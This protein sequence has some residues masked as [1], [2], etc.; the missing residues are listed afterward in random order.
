MRSAPFRVC[1]VQVGRAVHV[2]GSRCGLRRAAH[3][4]WRRWARTLSGSKLS[5]TIINLFNRDPERGEAASG[6][7]VMDPRLRRY[8]VSFSKKF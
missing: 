4:D 8:I 3:G 1:V 6:R 7:I 5:V 2:F